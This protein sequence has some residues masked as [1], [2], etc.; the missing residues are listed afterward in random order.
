MEV[1]GAFRFAGVS[2]DHRNTEG[3]MTGCERM[4]HT[5]SLFCI[6]GVVS[7]RLIAP[8]IVVV[9]CG[10][11]DHSNLLRGVDSSP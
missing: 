4:K 5:S 3:G 8:K 10:C 9:C 6:L 7:K 11:V 2:D 1:R